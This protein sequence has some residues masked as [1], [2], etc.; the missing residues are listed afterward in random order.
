LIFRSTNGTPIFDDPITNFGLTINENQTGNVTFEGPFQ[1]NDGL[2]LTLGTVD[3]G[4]NLT[5]GTQVTRTDVGAINGQINY[6]GVVAFT[7]D[8]TNAAAKTITTGDEF[9]ATATTGAAGALT[10]TTTGGGAMTLKLEETKTIG[11]GNGALTTVGP[12]DL[13]SSTLNI[14]GANLTHSISGDVTSGTVAFNLG[15]NATIGA[16][17]AFDLPNVTAA[18]STAGGALLTV[19]ALIVDVDNVTASGNASIALNNSGDIDNI[20]NSGAGNITTANGNTANVILNSGTGNI[21]LNNAAAGAYTTQGITQSGSGVVTYGGNVN[22]ITVNGDVLM[23]G[24]VAGFNTTAA[25]ANSKGIYFPATSTNVTV[26]GAVTNS[27]SLSGSSDEDDNDFNAIIDFVNSGT[28]TITGTLSN[29]VSGSIAYTAGGD[30]EL[31]GSILLRSGGAMTFATVL[32]NSTVTGPVATTFAIPL[33]I[34]LIGSVGSIISYSNVALTATNVQNT[35]ASN[36]NALNNDINFAANATTNTLTSVSTTGAAGGD[37]VFGNGATTVSGSVTNSRTSNTATVTFGTAALTVS[38]SLLNSNSGVTNINSAASNVGINTVNVS[39]G[40]VTFASTTGNVTFTNTTV[41]GGAVSLAALTSGIMSFGN[42]NVSGGTTNVGTT[43]GLTT[44]LPGFAVQMT[45]FVLSGGALNFLGAAGAEAIQVAGNI[46]MTN[47][48]LNLNLMDQLFTNGTSIVIGGANTNPTITNE[49]GC[50]FYFDEPI[51]NVLQTITIG[52]QI[53]EWDG[54][55]SIQNP[56]NITEVVK[57]TGGNFRVN[58]TVTFNNTGVYNA[59]TIDGTKFYIGKNNP[60]G[61]G[62]NFVNTT[63]YKSVNDGR[64]VMQGNVAQ[65]VTVGVAPTTFGG[66]EVDNNAGALVDV[67]FAGAVPGV[68]TDFFYLAEGVVDGANVDFN[69]ATTYPTIVRNEGSFNAAPT[70]TSM[71]NVAYI[72]GVN[73]VT[74]VEIPNAANKLNNLTVATSNSPTQ[75]GRA[76][77]TISVNTTVNGT[78]TVYNRQGINIANAIT[79]TLAGAQARLFNPNPGMDLGSGGIIGNTGTGALLLGAA[80]GTTIT[81]SANGGSW[82]PAITV[83]AAS[84]GNQITAVDGLVDDYYGGDGVFGGAAEDA[85]TDGD[86]TFLGAPGTGSLTTTFNQNHTASPNTD[87]NLIPD[88]RNATVNSTWTLG[89]NVRM[90]GNL[91]ANSGTIDV[92]ANTLFVDGLAHTINGAATVTGA[93][94]LRWQGQGNNTLAIPGGDATLSVGTYE[95]AVDNTAPYTNRFEINTNDLILSGSVVVTSGEMWLGN[96]VPVAQNITVTGNSLTLSANGSIPGNGILI[97]NPTTPPLTFTFTGTPAISNVTQLGDVTMAGTG[98]GL[99]INGTYLHTAGALNYASRTI[100][101][102]GTFTHAGGTYEATTGY[103]VFTG[104]TFNNNAAFTIPNF[105]YAAGA[106][107][108]TNTGMMTVSG[109]LD[110]QPAGGATWTVDNTPGA[111]VT[112]GLTIND[113]VVVTWTRGTITPQPI[114]AGAIDLT[115]TSDGTTATLPVEIWPTAVTVNTLTVTNGA[116]NTNLLTGTRTVATA[117][118]HNSGT[119]SLPNY[120]APTTDPVVNVTGATFTINA[121]NININGTAAI[122]LAASSQLNL[123]GGSITG[124]GTFAY[125]DQQNVR[126]IAGFITAVVTH[127]NNANVTFAVN[128]A[129]FGTSNELP[130]T[131][132]NVTLTRTVNSA[133]AAVTIA[134]NTTVNGTLD[135]KNDLTIPALITLSLSGNMTVSSE[136][137]TF[138]LATNPVLTFTGTLAFVGASDQIVTLLGNQGFGNI[139]INKAASTNTVT[140]VGGNMVMNAGAVVTFT[141]GVLVTGVNALVLQTPLLGGGQGFVNAFVAPNYSH[142]MGNVSR[143][144]VNTGITATSSVP[145]IIFPVGSMTEYRPAIITFNNTT[146]GTPTMPNT[147]FT[148][149]HQDVVATGVVGLPIANGVEPNVAVSRYPDFNW[150]ISTFP[151]SVSPSIAFDIELQGAGF[152]DYDDVN[153]VRLIRRQ[154]SLTDTQNQWLLQG[155]TNLFYDN[156]VISGVPAVIVRNAQ[157]GFVQGGAL[158]TY[159]M[160]SRLSVAN[161]IANQNL[162]LGGAAFTVNLNNPAVFAGNQGA[163]VYAASST[164]PSVATAAVANGVLTVTPVAQGSATIQV[165]ATDV[166]NDFTT[167]SFTVNVNPPTNF[168]VT[169]TVTYANTANDPF[170]GATVQLWQ[171]GS[172]V[173]TATTDAAGAFNIPAVTNGTYTMTA[174]HTGTWPVQTATEAFVVAAHFAGTTPLTGTALAVADVNGSGTVNNTDALLIVRRFA[175]LVSS[176]S[177]GDWYFQQVPVTVNGAAVAQNLVG[178]AYGDTRLND[179]PTAAPKVIAEQFAEG[180]VLKVAPN[181]E[182]ELP[183]SVSE[184]VNIGALSLAF[185]YPTDMVELV[186]VKSAKDGLLFNDVEGRVT[187]AWADMTGGKSS[188]SLDKNAT[189]LVL[190]FKP[191]ENFKPGSSFSL[192]VD[193]VNEIADVNG[194]VLSKSGLKAA[195]VESF[196]PKEFALGQNYPNPFN[197]STVIEYALPENA[198][199][200]LTIYNVLGQEVARLIDAE[201]QAGVYKFNWNASGLASG[202]YIYN[203]QVE[204]PNKNFS[205][206]KRMMLLK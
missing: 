89:A 57:I 78:L 180:E 3:G 93:G 120:G 176:F 18:K 185:N 172:V 173:Y 103:I 178:A 206:T 64:I 28:L 201:Q 114:F 133:N 51:P 41:S 149:N 11:N 138:A 110:V 84:A 61:T 127:N 160:S 179:A 77:V 203:M 139:T 171:G 37:I 55:F 29:T 56:A 7:Y 76:T 102:A 91:V 111:G 112:S 36:G 23:S 144:T 15:G 88:L 34:N 177:V 53:P 163:L 174:A 107:A 159:G 27:A 106:T 132:N 35:S 122:N 200:T 121:G 8:N 104:G 126:V 116:N 73:H 13:N 62:G 97:L 6:T 85:T 66:F 96:N 54:P 43:T 129:A 67:A 152:T 95:V 21:T 188:I 4:T 186:S 166:N 17:G 1:F 168:P 198:K 204:A 44:V 170:V 98:V 19:G 2:N 190:T 109:R 82:L 5:V 70:F 165:A 161:A 145:T 52:N 156:A 24:A 164:N 130:V 74:A 151:I 94:K 16:T 30:G 101:L 157:A 75:A 33:G 125:G 45:S 162:T 83:G 137:G 71:V 119:L 92:Q 158:F 192:E 118:V 108:F 49:V 26:N 182:F 205:D 194:N 115:V 50:T 153:K 63:G 46:S 197:P 58:N 105:R 189:L 134:R 9:P 123:N 143:T 147:T 87:A 72:G 81:G 22:V 100:T 40:T 183:I 31:N 184:K 131:V 154:G 199:V 60:G 99:T 136:A 146:S 113:G 80:T 142:V 12:L 150:S 128:G 90:S 175:G 169:G 196:I 155:G 38:G 48:T 124:A 148:V 20:T 14:V 195:T 181:K 69:N 65:T 141:N 68:F 10:T 140:L 39:G 202:V 117:V 86:L 47:G 135:V 25:V 59:I 42:L 79:L 187:L 193:G 191:T 167:T 32:N